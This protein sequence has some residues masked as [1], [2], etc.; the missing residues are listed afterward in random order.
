M[1]CAAVCWADNELE[2]LTAD[3]RELRVARKA[4]RWGGTETKPEFPD[5][6]KQF[7]S[8]NTPRKRQNK[9]KQIEN[10]THLQ[11]H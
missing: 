3:S 8:K 7:P 1:L 6:Q 5:R 11:H 2:S 10:T 9:K 4:G